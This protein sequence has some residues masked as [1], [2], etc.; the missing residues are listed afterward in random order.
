MWAVNTTFIIGLHSRGLGKNS[1]SYAVTRLNDILTII[2][3]HFKKYP[4]LHKRMQISL[5]QKER[6][7][8]NEH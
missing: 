1:C 2:I 7:K 4:L 3:P 5:W 8:K 6:K